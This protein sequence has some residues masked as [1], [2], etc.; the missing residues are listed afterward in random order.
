MKIDKK[1]IMEKKL[2]I[3]VTIIILVASIGYFS[4]VKAD[5]QGEEQVRLREYIATRGDIT[6]GINGAGSIKLQEVKQSFQGEVTIEEVYVKEGEKVAKGDKIAKISMKAVEEKL[7]EQRQNLERANITVEQARNAKQSSLLNNDLG[8]AQEESKNQYEAS[9]KEITSRISMV[10]GNLNEV[11]KKISDSENQVNILKNDEVANKDEIEE[12]QQKINGLLEE[13][14]V[15]ERELATEENRLVE[16]EDSRKKQLE[17]ENKESAINIE[18]NS[19]AMKDA[20]NTIRLAEIEVEKIIKEIEKIEKLMESPIVYAEEDGIVM[21]IG[22]ANSVVIP[23]DPIVVLGNLNIAE[24]E[25]I[26][27]QGDISKINKEQNV[28]LEISAYEDEVFSG[29]IQTIN[30]KPNTEGVT[31]SYKVTVEVDSNG[32]QLLEGMGVN[33]EFILKEVKDVIILSNKAITLKDGK[34]IVQIQNSDGT[35]KETEIVTGFSD[36]RNSEIISGLKEGDVVV[37][38]G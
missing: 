17:K 7:E 33:A 11:I 15:L 21:S 34:Q 37:I 20:D 13:K 12:L 30:L 31:T 29:K 22:T 6:A 10:E 16:L 3:I 35:L 19:I 32:F 5:N 38:E 2:F 1:F 28:N 8:A 14:K 23:N 26:V 18:R 25:I 27:G 4:R 24:A 36:G 9:K